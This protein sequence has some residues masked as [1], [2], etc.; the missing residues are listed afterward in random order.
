MT[1][2]N[3][4]TDVDEM[5]IDVESIDEQV[6]KSKYKKSDDFIGILGDFFG[7]LDKKLYLFMFIIFLFVT[8]DIFNDNILS[9]FSNAVEHRE[10]TSKGALIQG[11]FQVLFVIIFKLLIDAG[12]A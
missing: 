7:G 3:D 11:L 8:S 1:D 12:V 9:R 10:A 6:G 5:D 4:V 2:N